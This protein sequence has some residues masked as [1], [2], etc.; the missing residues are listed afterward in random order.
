[1]QEQRD[2][3]VRVRHEGFEERAVGVKEVWGGERRLEVEDVVLGN[4]RGGCEMEAW[5][6]S[7]RGAV[8][9]IIPYNIAACQ[10]PQHQITYI[11]G[12]SEPNF[13]ISSLLSRIFHAIQGHIL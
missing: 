9:C 3:R 7:Y 8:Q 13:M 2:D 10:P 6:D 11:S 12:I 5:E 4:L 1:M